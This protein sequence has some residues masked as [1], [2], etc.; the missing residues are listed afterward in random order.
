MAR[1]GEPTQLYLVVPCQGAG[2]E[3]SATLARIQAACQTGR[4]STVLLESDS[5]SDSIRWS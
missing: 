5:G 2:L 3:A 4:V 1:S